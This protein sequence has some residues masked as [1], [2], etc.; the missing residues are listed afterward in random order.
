MAADDRRII[1][2]TVSTYRSGH[3]MEDGA[4]R[5]WVMNEFPVG[6][7]VKNMNIAASQVTEDWYNK[8]FTFT[9]WTILRDTNG[10]TDAEFLCI[11][12]ENPEGGDTIE[13]TLTGLEEWEDNNNNWE[14]DSRYYNQ[15][16]YIRLK[17]QNIISLDINGFLKMDRVH[18][19]CENEAT[20]KYILAK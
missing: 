17:P 11:K 9:G 7:S 16:N 6:G 1:K 10:A 5:K 4:T 19:Y 18:V 20:I 13:I 14:A 8:S 3:L 15:G 12:N 2:S